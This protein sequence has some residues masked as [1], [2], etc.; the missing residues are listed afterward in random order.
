MSRHTRVL[1]NGRTL[2]GGSAGRVMHL[3]SGLRLAAEQR[4]RS[5]PGVEARLV[6]LLLDG[7]FADPQ[8]GQV[9]GETGD[10][11]VVIPIK[12]RPEQL[13]R[14]L[15]A[16]A[17]V[18]VVVVDDGSADPEP[19][20]VLCHRHGAQ[21]VRHPVNRGPAA[22]RNTGVR[23]CTTAFVALVDSDVVPQPGW[24][25]LLRAHLDDPG[26]G[27][28][29]PRVLGLPATDADRLLHAYER[30][31]SSLDLG[32]DPGPVGPGR[33]ISYVPS[34]ALL[35]RRELL[36]DGFDES[37]RCGEDVDLVWRVLSA[38][39]QVRY[40]P[41]SRVHHG[42]RV[43]MAQ[44]LTRKAFYGTSAAPLAQRH[45]QAVSPVQLPPWL[46]LVVIAA[47]AQR[48]WSPPV[49]ALTLLITMARLSRRLDGY[50]HPQLLAADL[51]GRAT[52]SSVRHLSSAVVRH[53]WPLSL[54]A[55]L[56]SVRARRVLLIAALTDVVSAH[57]RQRPELDLLRFG[58]LRRLDDLAYGAGLWLG[59][60]RSRR[61]AALVPRVRFG[62]GSSTP[63]A[64]GRTRL[65]RYFSR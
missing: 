8:I 15:P 22:A 27:L 24:L 17:G 30:A 59:V 16:L 23:H 34:A 28:V 46:L 7:G 31:A 43:R 53:Y 3:R 21:L 45:R 54:L 36:V 13:A 42:H 29:A 64:G 38:G 4:L 32:P 33:L 51:V 56:C 48:R 2:V 9:P 65:R 20:A 49:M 63:K 57:R 50:R 44:W 14:L 18:E 19:I 62:S 61:L 39:W 11:T 47:V 52:V 5:R 10:I 25:A 35:G 12:D 40:E 1:D 55:A 26:V 6:R 37:M 60:C 41:R 58:I